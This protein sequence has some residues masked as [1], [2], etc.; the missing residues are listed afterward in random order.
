MRITTY[1]DEE[2]L[3]KLRDLANHSGSKYQTILNQVLR[4]CFFGKK[5]GLVARI[6]KLEKAVFKK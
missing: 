6:E 1:L 3:N 4:D 5:E 2:V